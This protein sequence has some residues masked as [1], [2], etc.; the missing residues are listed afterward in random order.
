MPLA[1]WLLDGDVPLRLPCD[2]PPRGRPVSWRDGALGPLATW[3]VPRA[4]ARSDA[5]D[6]RASGRLAPLAA[7]HPDLPDLASRVVP[8]E[9]DPCKWAG[10]ELDSPAEPSEHPDEARPVLEHQ[11]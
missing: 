1:A 7:D 10:L 3:P 4:T 6:G 5:W 2:G 9:P 8:D 11:A